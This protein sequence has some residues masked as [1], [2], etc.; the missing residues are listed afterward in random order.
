MTAV[1][2][3][4]TYALDAAARLEAV[5][6]TRKPEEALAAAVFQ[7]NL[8]VKK[9]F[10]QEIPALLD[11]QGTRRNTQAESRPTGKPG[12]GATWLCGQPQ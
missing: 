10:R 11:D 5:L 6:T 9:Y 1:G 7:S 2:E 8:F 4:V 3:Y 12:R